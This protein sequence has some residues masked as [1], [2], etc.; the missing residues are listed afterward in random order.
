M[1]WLRIGINNFLTFF[2]RG[3]N[4]HLVQRKMA[5]ASRLE[6]VTFCPTLLTGV[7]GVKLEIEYAGNY[8]FN[9]GPG[10]GGEYHELSCL[11]MDSVTAKFN[12]Y[13]LSEICSEFTSL[14]DPNQPVP[15]LPKYVGGSD[16]HLLVGIKNTFLRFKY[17]YFFAQ[18]I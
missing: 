4:V 17:F 18:F 14:L 7:G 16:A 5:V 6:L 9:L 3:A 12:K 10:I 15:P 1:Q 8:Q 2:D 11:G 13:E